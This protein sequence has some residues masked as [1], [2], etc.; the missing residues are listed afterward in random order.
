MSLA[1]NHRA[2]SPPLE[3]DEKEFTQTASNMR[4]RGMSF[5][6]QSIRHSTETDRNLSATIGGMHMDE[7][8]QEL[9]HDQED[10]VTLF[11]GQPQPQPFGA[12][13]MSS[14][15]VRPVNMRIS[16]ERAIREGASDVEMKGPMSLLGHQGLDWEL[17]EPESIGLEDLDELLGGF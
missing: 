5:E 17:R 15:F 9:V 11:G 8:Q 2:Q 3:G 16:M 13:L 4:I 7:S 1:H 10:G 12:G 14:P 6:D